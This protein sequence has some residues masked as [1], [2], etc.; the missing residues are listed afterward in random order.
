MLIGSNRCSYF[1][2]N[3]IINAMSDLQCVITKVRLSNPAFRKH[4]IV[5][6]CQSSFCQ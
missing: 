4:K 6:L 5:V 2:K 1:S 3:D